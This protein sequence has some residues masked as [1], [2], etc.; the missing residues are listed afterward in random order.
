MV[1]RQQPDG[2]TVISV[3]DDGVG[4]D[5]QYSSKLF[6][7]FQGLHHE[8]EFEGTGIGLANV[9]RMVERHGGRVWAESAIDH[10]ATF[11]YSLPSSRITT[12]ENY[13]LT[14][15]HPAG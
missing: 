8:D 12:R 11:Y 9:R 15:S 4:F 10:G 14:Q 7:V 3:R 13:E 2:E 1:S 5:M 6:Q